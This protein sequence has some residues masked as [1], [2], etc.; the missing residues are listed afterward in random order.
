MWKLSRTAFVKVYYG[1]WSSQGFKGRLDKFTKIHLVT[2]YIGPFNL[3]YLRGK[4]WC[5]SLK[6]SSSGISF[7][8]TSEVYYEATRASAWPTRP[9]MFI[10]TSKCRRKMNSIYLGRNSSATSH[11]RPSNYVCPFCILDTNPFV[12]D[13]FFCLISHPSVLPV[14]YQPLSFY[15][16]TSVE[17]IAGNLWILLVGLC[18]LITSDSLLPLLK[19]VLQTACNRYHSLPDKGRS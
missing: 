2:H 11:T 6:Y 7:W 13:I 8:A 12:R 14:P 19:K 16:Q 15:S 17:H 1:C 4:Q 9:A 10:Q 3:Q 18:D 5:I